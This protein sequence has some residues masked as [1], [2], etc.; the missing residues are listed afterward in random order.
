M[1]IPTSLPSQP[2]AHAQQP[3]PYARPSS[4]HP[5]QHQ[6]QHQHQ[7]P[8]PYAQ[9][10][11]SQSMPQPSTPSQSGPPQPPIQ[12]PPS[13]QSHS[14]TTSKPKLKAGR[15]QEALAQARNPSSP[16]EGPPGG[17]LGLMGGTRPLDLSRVPTAERRSMV[18][19][20]IDTRQTFSPP[21]SSSRI[22]SPDNSQPAQPPRV[23][24]RLPQSHLSVSRDMDQFSIITTTELT[25]PAA[26]R[27]RI[28]S[29]LH[30]YDDDYSACRL[31]RTYIGESLED[32]NGPEISDDE[33]W[34]LCAN[35]KKGDSIILLV[36]Q[37]KPTDSAPV[38][39][40]REHSGH[41]FPPHITTEAVH[42]KSG[43]LG[44]SS[45]LSENL[46]NEFFLNQ[47]NQPGWHGRGMSEQGPYSQHLD[48]SPANSPH[49]SVRD[50]TLS[51]LSSPYPNNATSPVRSPR[52]RTMDE[53]RSPY[54]WSD[55]TSPPVHMRGPRSPNPP[56]HMSE[57]G[58]YGAVPRAQ[59]Q[60]PTPTVESAPANQRSFGM[61][62]SGPFLH[63][64]GVTGA[65][66]GL[67][68]TPGQASSQQRSAPNSNFV[69]GF[70]PGGMGP[71][72]P[73]RVGSG[74]GSKGLQ[75]AKSMNDMRKE[76][77]AAPPGDGRSKSPGPPG[78]YGPQGPFIAR[79]VSANANMLAGRYQPPA[80][81]SI[82]GPNVANALGG[83]NP[84]SNSF[85][86]ADGQQNYAPSPYGRPPGSSPYSQE[87]PGN[88]QIQ[89]SPDIPRANGPRAPHPQ[90]ARSLP[91]EPQ[92]YPHAL[93]Q[94]PPAP[95][96]TPPLTI[97]NRVRAPSEKS[98]GSSSSMQRANEEGPYD[99]MQRPG[100]AASRRSDHSAPST[101]LISPG[102]LKETMTLMRMMSTEVLGFVHRLQ[103]RKMTKQRK[104]VRREK[105]P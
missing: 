33:L 82:Y 95:G 81:S 68:P 77:N 16:V 73:L 59:V 84:P 6:H 96:T 15:F 28:L 12:R 65:P 55:Q 92:G 31:Y 22:T 35:Q 105:G 85:Y 40:T 11:H 67:P 88:Q 9:P 54:G 48:P 42:N 4:T 62:P 87:R 8:H 50:R 98:S 64:A 58:G 30:V 1:A 24:G 75:S 102:P 2:H 56:R 49:P 74:P 18:L 104:K 47:N 63:P 32:I 61:G 38:S 10:T 36:R 86:R 91:A 5:T 39:A 37:V 41:V 93:R 66:R 90:G 83:S 27:E 76:A 44:S 26:I 99:G 53:L 60:A 3:H 13:S 25:S 45:T 20:G 14:S 17:G 80:P 70:I 78:G 29:K 52:Q 46:V 51:D 21:G 101:P 23:W 71:L 89:S 103:K 72:G 34:D 7:H 69:G 79:H 43:S 19:S 94:P 57:E 97:P 100:S